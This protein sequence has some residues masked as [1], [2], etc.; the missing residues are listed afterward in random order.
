MKALN[1]FFILIMGSIILQSCIAD[2]RTALIKKEGITTQNTTK[3]KALLEAAWRKHGFDNLNNHKTYSF[4]ASDTWRGMMGKM[5]KPWPEAKSELNFKFQV[6]TF[7]S[8]ISFLD[9]KRSGTSAGLQNWKYYEIEN[10]NH[11]EFMKV[12][13]KINFALPAYHYFFEMIDR[14]KNASIISYAGEKEFRGAHYDLVL[15]TWE[16]E[17][18]HME[19]DQYIA[20]INKK[21]GIMDYSE[22]S[23]RDNYLKIPGYK[24]F[25]GAVELKDFRNV[26]GVMVPHEQ[27]VYL[28]G[29]KESEKRHVHKLIVRNFKFD[30]FDLNVLYPDSVDTKRATDFK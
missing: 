7:N 30:A 10:G 24:A 9:G 18:P 5:G 26:D 29:V 23:L 14:L 2:M 21:T 1:T 8:Q 6:G 13:K 27:I 28:N 22:Y 15:C 19:D 20:W 11:P 3:G 17:K 4:D 25:Y 16:T 12:N